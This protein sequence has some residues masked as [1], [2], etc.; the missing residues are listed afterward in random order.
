MW[1]TEAKGLGLR[2]TRGGSKT[3]VYRWRAAG[4]SYRTKVAAI[5]IESARN[6]AAQYAAL[7]AQGLDPR[8]EKA[9]TIQ[10]EREYRKEATRSIATLAD[11]WEAYIAANESRWSEAH[12]RDHSKSMQVAGQPRKRSKKKTVAGALT[13]LR[14]TML[15]D[16]NR[17][18]V[19]NWLHR[20]AARRPATTA[21]SFRL[22]RAA[23]NWAETSDHF[24]G[25]IPPDA[26]TAVTVRRAVPSPGVRDDVLQ[27]EQLRPWFE[28]VRAIPNPVISAFLQI[29]L[30]T[31]ARRNELAALAWTDIDFTWR[32][33][34]IHDKVDGERSI[35]LTPY[36]ANLM[37][38]L[39]AINNTPPKK[40]LELRR[41]QAKKAIQDKW[42]TSPWVFFSPTAKSGRLQD[43]RARHKQACRAAGI[44]GL[45]IHGL[46]RSFGSLSEWV[47]CPTGISAQIMGHKPSA[48]AEK[49]YRRRPIDLLRSW[50]SKIE[51]WML[52]EAGVDCATADPNR[53]G[54]AN[55]PE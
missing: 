26:T 43:P 47:E 40:P 9:R 30:L 8:A 39:S 19:E 32:T 38:R 18:C 31:G 17:R 51:N 16:L 7:V 55:A 37:R 41:R 6:V 12:R 25:L 23:V 48:I 28:Q 35:P 36:V 15:V 21:R 54:L 42:T 44:D 3:F 45:T 20:E 33:L 1:D 14:S 11:L 4:Q 50:H 13:P 27:R 22:L 2:A 29:A 53:I 10:Q 34:R 52:F 5:D 49:H 46:R 24:A